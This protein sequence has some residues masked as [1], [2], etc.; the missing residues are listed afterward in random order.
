ML[1]QNYCYPALQR[2]SSF[3]TMKLT[4]KSSIMMWSGTGY[5]ISRLRE[6]RREVTHGYNKVPV[7]TALEIHE[8]YREPGIVTGYRKNYSVSQVI[9]SLF[10]SNN[11]TLNF[12]THFIPTLYFVWKFFSLSSTMPLFSDAYLFPLACHMV[13]SCT[14]PLAS[15][16]A[17]AF[18]C[19]SP[20]ATYVCFFLDYAAL[21]LYSWGAAI[22]YYAYVF[23]ESAFN[24]WYSQIFLPVA[25]ANAIFSTFLACFSRF[26][27]GPV[28][29]VSLRLGAFVAPFVWDSIPLVY[30]LLTCD[31]DTDTCGESG[32][33][34]LMQFCAVLAA[35]FFYASHIPER[36]APGSFDI[37]GNS[38]NLL[39]LFSIIGT[40]EQIQAAII[41]LTGRRASLKRIG[42]VVDPVW[43]QIVTPTLFILSLLIIV[44]S[45]SLVDT[46]QPFCSGMGKCSYT[47]GQKIVL[48]NSNMN[49]TSTNN[50]GKKTQ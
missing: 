22:L 16:L 49:S 20:M 4:L 41:D 37:V 17:H 45:I 32:H 3:F 36:F 42:W 43:A 12:W 5:F 14:Y 13:A 28:L 15:C 40:H 21:S 23:P 48:R 34:H 6:V 19:I 10:Q 44:I 26:V 50:D 2:V 7:H 29:I 25:A 9:F 1:N 38:H 8:S 27:D 31:P 30:R 35:A 39:H 47:C 46:V 18:S 24:T 11:E 33:Y